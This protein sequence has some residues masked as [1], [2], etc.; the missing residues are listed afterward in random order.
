M[1]QSV[2]ANR[3]DVWDVLPCAVNAMSPVSMLFTSRK[4]IA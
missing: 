3:F 4:E 1:K 2:K